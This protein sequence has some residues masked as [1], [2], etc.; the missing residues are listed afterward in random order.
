MDAAI[1]QEVKKILSEEYGL[2]SVDEVETLDGET[3]AELYEQLKFVQEEY[4]LSDEDME[5]IL[6]EIE[7]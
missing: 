1:Y 4:D 6:D 3:M 2:Q 7:L 5:D